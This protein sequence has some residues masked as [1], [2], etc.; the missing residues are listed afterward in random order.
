MNRT[1]YLVVVLKEG[2]TWYDFVGPGCAPAVILKGGAR[3]LDWWSS[4][5]FG[6]ESAARGVMEMCVAHGDDRDLRVTTHATIAPE[7]IRMQHWL[8]YEESSESQREHA[9]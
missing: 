7:E 8:G 9:G 2:E 6:S 4:S 1:Y 3:S 5:A